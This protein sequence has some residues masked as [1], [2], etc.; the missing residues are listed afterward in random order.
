MQSAKLTDPLKEVIIVKQ[1]HDLGGGRFT[2]ILTDERVYSCQP[3]GSAGDRDPGTAGGY[4]QCA[5]SGN[6]A[7]FKPVDRYFCKA[8]VEVGDL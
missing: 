3:D 1:R 4:E 2:L 5:I 7:T 6:I 8:F